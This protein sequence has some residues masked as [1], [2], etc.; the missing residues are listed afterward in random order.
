M[1]TNRFDL[2]ARVACEDWLEDHDF[3]GLSGLVG[4]GFAHN[5]G[6]VPL[7]FD[8]WYELMGAAKKELTANGVELD[9]VNAMGRLIYNN[10]FYRLVTSGFQYLPLK[11]RYTKDWKPVPLDKVDTPLMLGGIALLAMQMRTTSQ[12]DPS[13]PSEAAAHANEA[14]QE[15]RNTFWSIDRGDVRIQI[16]LA[17][18]RRLKTNVDEMAALLPHLEPDH[19]NN[20]KIML[21]QYYEVLM[22]RFSRREMIAARQPWEDLIQSFRKALA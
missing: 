16:D 6:H 19:A 18:L 1:I 13:T 15:L 7:D 11:K 3:S 4:Y 8:H 5:Q 2:T 12:N 10:R 9:H 21:R 20:I 17:K 14:W 22:E